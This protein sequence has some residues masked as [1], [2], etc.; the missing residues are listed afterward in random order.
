MRWFLILLPVLFLANC[1]YEE[2]TRETGH[3]GKARI[4]P[5]LAAER[6]LAEYDYEVESKSGWPDLVDG[7]LSM[8]MLPASALSARSYVNDIDDWTRYGGHVVV[9]L[10]HGEAY[11]NDWNN[12]PFTAM[13]EEEELPEAFA[14]WLDE[15]GVE[16]DFE[17]ADDDSSTVAEKVDFQGVEYEV[18]MEAEAQPL[19]PAGERVM[20]RS[21]GYGEGRVTVVADA[22]PFRNRWIGDY[23]HAALLLAMEEESPIYGSTAFEI[24]RAHV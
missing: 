19:S 21:I 16:I 17:G 14:A 1:S 24:G 18:F 22:R 9:L 6:F 4:N 3:K 20:I 11:H 12:S 23:D 15:L 10:N 2:T 13:A 8:V 5:Y 7:D